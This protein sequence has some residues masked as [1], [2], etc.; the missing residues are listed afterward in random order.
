V[1]T[2]VSDDVERYRLLVD[3]L[4]SGVVVHQDGAVVYVNQALARLMRVRPRDAIGMSIFDFVH[5]DS[6][7]DLRR[8]LAGLL[9]PGVPSEPAEAVLVRADGSTVVVESVSALTTWDGRPALQ[10]ILRD[11]TEDKQAQAS[12]RF[13][14][15]LVEQVSDA[16][17]A[18]DGRHRVVSWNPAAGAI[19][20]L[21][22][23]QAAGRHITDLLGPQF[24][25]DAMIR[26]CRA[27]VRACRAEVRACRADGAALV[28]RATATPLVDGS[29][30]VLLC[31]DETARLDAERRFASVVSA[32]EEAVVV[33]DVKGVV[34][35]VNPAAEQVF[36][37]AARHL[38]GLRGEDLPLLDDAGRPLGDD[39]PLM[40]THRTGRSHHRRAAMVDRPDGSRVW[41]T[42]H[43][44]PLTGSN[45]APA[46]YR[47]AV[48]PC[49]AVVSLSD[50]TDRRADAQRLEHA[51]TH[52]ALTGLPNRVMLLD[53]IA[54]ARLRAAVS[55]AL[56]AV[57]FVD[58]DD[59]KV[60]NDTAGHGAGD[61]A[62]RL[63]ATRLTAGVRAGDVVG[64]IGGDEFVVLAVLR[65]VEGAHRLAERLLDGLTR[66]TG[67]M[68][69]GRTLHAS[70]GIVTA[71]AD[72]PRAPADL[73]RDADS[74]MYQAKSGGGR[75]VALY[76]ANLR[77]GLLR[78]LQLGNDLRGALGGDDMWVAYQP[79]VD[80][81]KGAW[82]GAEALS[83]WNHPELGV[84]PPMEFV[85]IAEQ[86]RLI[87]ALGQRSLEV[88]CRDAMAIRSGGRS[89]FTVS[90]NLSMR[91]L[92]NASLADLVAATLQASGLP[93][94]ALCLEL[95]ESVM[96]DDAR[97]GPAMAGLR[98]LGVQMSIDD[99]GTG[100]SSLG[101]LRNLPVD[102]L[103][104]DRTFIT[105]L[106]TDE[107][108]RHLVR[109]IIGLAH[110]LD[111]RVVAEGVET[112][113]HVEILAE[114]QCDRAQGYYY[115]RP[116]PLAELTD[117]LG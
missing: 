24:H 69:R 11:L 105:P 110:S 96:A 99:F 82:V 45:A 21:D 40:D 103:K 86:T 102:E 32:L 56:V 48:L 74:A 35:A 91:Q 88:A 106:P 62:L 100:Y 68:L 97:T 22:A 83:R 111:L 34:S 112:H 47:D 94:D 26:A 116:M 5:P 115:G 84:I 85:E 41:L 101:R 89:G 58:L 60:I 44:S 77:E 76:D 2:A 27:E 4:P 63:V 61:E 46:G 38:V 65:D 51:A 59:F 10:A 95:T 108:A 19:F 7:D 72:D 50:V 39:S 6:R 109:G 42:A 66:P 12:L 75:R 107:G 36:G 20:G 114:L 104:I 15:A 55:G 98:E 81:R 29:G 93:P 113:A 87:H 18:T 80:L 71:G 25:P 14:A 9:V 30:H 73:L 8:R 31:S 3:L 64:R 23:E 54:R 57:L 28:V 92:E 67:G 17:I 13:Q 117:R 37:L 1:T 78:R 52:D 43:S 70:V 53:E 33:V 16:I 49:A 79:L 90:V